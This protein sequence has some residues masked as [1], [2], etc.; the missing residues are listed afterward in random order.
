ML[1]KEISGITHNRSSSTYTI[2]NQFAST[3][4]TSISSALS[5]KVHFK[6]LQRSKVMTKTSCAILT[7][8][9][10]FYIQNKHVLLLENAISYY[11]IAVTVQQM[12]IPLS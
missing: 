7:T 2:L 10:C 12:S 5:V 8:V 3:H 11:L 4:S 6:V 1:R 9:H